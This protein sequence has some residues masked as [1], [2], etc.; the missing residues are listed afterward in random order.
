MTDAFEE[1]NEAIAQEQASKRWK[2]SA[3]FIYGAGVLL[4]LGVAAFEGWR[5]YKNEQT[6]KAA[7]EYGA[8]MDSIDKNDIGGAK[9]Q[10]ETIAKGDGGFAAL[11]NNVLA[12]VDAQPNPQGPA[13]PA[14]AEKRLVEAAKDKGPIGDVAAL[15]LAYL[16]AD[17]TGLPELETQVKPLIDKGGPIGALARELIAAK[18]AA[19]GDVERARR[20][21]QALTLELDATPGMQERVQRAIAILPPAA[22]PAPAATPAAPAPSPVPTPA[23]GATP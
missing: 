13:N 5:W 8:A 4:I 10:L 6:E 23:A 15:K 21:Y 17:T 19:V 11:A 16:K 12:A 9:V 2:Q 14:A 1:V 7:K 20:D 3:P 22:A 18:A